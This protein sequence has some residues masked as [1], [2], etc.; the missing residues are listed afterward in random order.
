MTVENFDVAVIGGGIAGATSAAHIADAAS[1]VLLEQESELAHHTTSRSAAIYLEHDGGTFAALSS[2]SR[3]FFETAHEGL[4]APLLDPLPVLNVGDESLREQFLADVA[5]TEGLARPAVFVEGHQLVDLCPVL[6]P[7]AVTVGMLEPAAASLDVMSLHRLYLRMARKAGAEI[8]TQSRVTAITRRGSAWQVQSAGGAFEVGTIVNASGAWGDHVAELAG[9]EPIGLTPMRR[10]AF[11][12]PI[13][14]DPTGWP[15]VYAGQIG[16]SCYFKPEAGNQLL[17]SLADESPED[18]RDTRPEEIDIAQ[19]IDNI[20][21]ITTLDIRTVRTSW[22][23]QRT[24]AP[25]RNP[26]FGPDP[27]QPSFTWMVGQGGWGIVSSPA[28]GLV[29]RASVLGTPLPAEL[30][31]GGLTAERLSPQRLRS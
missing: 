14:V 24:F 1:V 25:D 20:K 31:A 11:T 18:P 15:F 22:A 9:V 23:G 19:A 29:A 13:T 5:E 8:R 16:G 12:T 6:R 30:I 26:V 7:D 2:A 4:D 27:E 10:T 28:A 21:A 3:P 17:C